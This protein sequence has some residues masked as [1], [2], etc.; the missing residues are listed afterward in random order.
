M[1]LSRIAVFFLLIAA[2]QFVHAD[3][4][5]PI[6][7]EDV[8]TMKR[9]GS[10]VVG[11]KGEWAVVSVTEPSY[12]EDGDVSDLWLLRVDGKGAPRRL[13]ATKEGESDVAWRPDGG[14]IAFAAKRGENEESQVYVLDMTGPGEAIQITDLSTGAGKPVWSPDGKRIAFESRV[15]PGLTGDEANKAEKEAREE[16]KY[17]VSAY[18]IFPI[19]HWDHWRDDRQVRL[20]VQDAVAGAVAKDLLADSSLVD[21]PGFDGAPTLT[22]SSLEAAWTPDGKALVFN[23]TSNLDQAA[24]A[25]VLYQLHLV[26][27]EGGETLQLTNAGD[28]SCTA[29]KFSP[30]GDALFCK[31]SPENE[32]VYNLEEVARFDW[33]PGQP[34]GAPAIL[35]EGFDQS[36]SEFEIGP[37]GRVF[38]T[39]ADAGRSRL[40]SVPAKGGEVKPLNPDSR[41][42]YSG[43]Q[44]AGKQLISKWESS[45]VPA[46][47]VRVDMRG[48]HEPVTA[49]NADRVKDIDLQPFREFWFENSKGR[50]VHSWLA[51]PPGFDESN[52]Y[53]LVLQIHGGPFSSSMDSQH[54]RW[55]AALLAAPGYVVLMTD[56]TGSVGY[57]EDFSRAIGGD[58]LKGPG[59]D[60]LEAA[61]A[62]IERFSFID[63]SRQAATGAS[64]GGH[65]VNWLQG[66][67]TRFDTLVGHAGLV[68]LEG[69]YSSSDT[70]YNREIM[71]GG[72]PWGESQVWREQSPSTYADSFSTPMLLTIGE[73]D[74]RVP[75][76]QTIAAWSYLQRNQ[77]PGRLLVFH[78]ANHWIMKGE[79]ARFFWQEVHAWLATYL[80]IED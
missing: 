5:R 17:N 13:T 1:N 25:R 49:F 50:R 68:D 48:R 70:I 46:E 43:L 16:R 20:F 34:L 40:Y 4:L 11:P 41:G 69:Q 79:E 56:Y 74:Y 71:N 60:L 26:T 29:P 19:R 53:P 35:T 30:D 57:G 55:S 65:L 63:G 75:I 62:A 67:T 14:A 39:A 3:E 54:V 23:A 51:L 45:A 36:V 18:E 7:H 37:E 12:E 59:E 22:S 10:P 27:L 33:V 21:Q 32:Y 64:Y 72:P 47:I 44:V 24:F 15:Y 6:T 2:A 76:N 9:L 66:T 80:F 52:K 61:D 78:D 42:V 28:W 31:L 58:P 38:L 8:W 73:K 77:V